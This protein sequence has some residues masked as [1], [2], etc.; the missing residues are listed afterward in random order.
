M[1]IL[2]YSRL[3]LIAALLL[4]G[5]TPA[6]SL[7]AAADSA[8]LPRTDFPACS[9]TV[10]TYCVSSVTFIGSVGVEGLEPPTSSL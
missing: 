10:N 1:H 2:R 8:R 6:R 4:G 9:T 3:A 7:T 5:L